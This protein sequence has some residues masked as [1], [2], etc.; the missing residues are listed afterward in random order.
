M[1]LAPAECKANRCLQN[2][3]SRLQQYFP[4]NGFT[5][6][7]SLK[8]DWPIPIDFLVPG[9]EHRALVIWRTAFGVSNRIN[10]ETACRGCAK[11]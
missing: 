9:P 10:R 3:S 11:N 7:W 5:G 2:V 4:L 8:P 6:S 1:L